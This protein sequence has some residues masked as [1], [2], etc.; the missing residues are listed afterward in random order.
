MWP[1]PS[2]NPGIHL[3]ESF[4]RME[5]GGFFS[6]N[7]MVPAYFPEMAAMP[8]FTAAF[9]RSGPSGSRRSE[10][11]SNFA[12][13]FWSVSI[14]QTFAG[15]AWKKYYSPQFLLLP[16]PGA[17]LPHDARGDNTVPTP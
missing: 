10:P 8:N 1:T 13:R 14:A 7:S 12:R 4:M 15:G 5:F 11:G 3:P 16:A 2:T 17:K 9:K 6:A